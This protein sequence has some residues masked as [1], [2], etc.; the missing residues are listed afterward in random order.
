MHYFYTFINTYFCQ[1]V[2]NLKL[3]KYL[4]VFRIRKKIIKI[5]MKNTKTPNEQA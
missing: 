4:G 2:K 3:P 5:K 1:N